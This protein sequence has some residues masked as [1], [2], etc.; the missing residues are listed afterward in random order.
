MLMTSYYRLGMLRAE[1]GFGHPVF[2]GA[3]CTIMIP[4]NMYFVEHSSQKRERLLYSGCLTFHLV[5][6]VLSNSRGS[7]LAFSC[8]AVLI[9]I[10]RLVKKSVKKLMATYL[11]IGAAALAVLILVASVSPMGVSFLGGIADSVISSVVP[12]EIH[13]AGA[14]EPVQTEPIQTEPDHAGESTHVSIDYG[15]NLNG[16][17]S[18]LKQLS[19]I[20]WTLSRQ[21]VFGFG[22]NAHVRGLICYKMNG[23]DWWRTETF[24]M[25]LVAIVCQ[26]GIVGLCGYIALYGSFLKSVFSKK[27]RGEPLM[28]FL[29]LA[30]AAYLICLCS[31]SSLDKMGWV[32]MALIVCAV[33]IF[34]KCPAIQL[35]NR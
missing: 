13:H 22:S 12:G 19:G 33:N 24:D 1:A 9:F 25:A 7:L 29:G 15:D 23:E 10:I 30:F 21:P 26:Y 4:L 28:E 11:P 34:N 27:Y 18:R 16:V 20:E 14:T 32:L 2:Y 31:I 17:S 6:L 3:F 35:R 5:A 8:L